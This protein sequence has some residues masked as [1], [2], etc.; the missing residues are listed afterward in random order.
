MTGITQ[1]DSSSIEYLSYFRCGPF[2]RLSADTMYIHRKIKN[3]NL[4]GGGGTTRVRNPMVTLIN[5]DILFPSLDIFKEF[6]L[7]FVLKISARFGLFNCTVNIVPNGCPQV[8]KT[9]FTIFMNPIRDK[10][11]E[12]T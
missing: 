5:V 7:N 9:I 4:R 3:M 10:K 11:S 1:K 2:R 12:F 6:F 8:R